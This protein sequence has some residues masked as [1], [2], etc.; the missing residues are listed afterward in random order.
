MANN[1]TGVTVIFAT[2]PLKAA[3]DP[4]VVN[5][6]HQDGGLAGGRQMRLVGIQV[7]T[8]FVAFQLGS[9]TSLGARMKPCI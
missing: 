9:S 5:R 7:T 2:D 8:R 4:A 3:P 6:G 1:P